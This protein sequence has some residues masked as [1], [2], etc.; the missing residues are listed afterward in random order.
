MTMTSITYKKAF[1]AYRALDSI[2]KEKDGRQI[3]D[4]LS[5]AA[6]KNMKALEAIAQKF[7]SLNEDKMIE[8]CSTDKDG[9]ITEPK[10]FTPEK[11]RQRKAFAEELAETEVPFVPFFTPD[12]KRISTLP[13]GTLMELE[14]ILFENID[15]I[16]A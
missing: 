10:K 3:N 5:Y 1:A 6:T 9:N 16:L 8:L 4:K 14:G 12:T 13:M 11:E 15:D 7:N 2:Q